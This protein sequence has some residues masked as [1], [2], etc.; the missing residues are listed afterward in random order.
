MKFTWQPSYYLTYIIE[1]WIM[2]QVKNVTSKV[3]F[4]RQGMFCNI[5]HV[6]NDQHNWIEFFKI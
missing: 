1:N 5:A 3:L 4:G 6:K 2:L